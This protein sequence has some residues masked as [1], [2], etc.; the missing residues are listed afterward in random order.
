LAGFLLFGSTAM[1][2]AIW[3]LV[4]ASNVGIAHDPSAGKMITIKVPGSLTWTIWSGYVEFVEACL[5]GPLRI[6]LDPL[7]ILVAV[8]RSQPQL[9]IAVARGLL[10]VLIAGQ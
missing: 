9:L 5:A 3:A 10:A 1:L 7:G 4:F 2:S 6:N 8:I